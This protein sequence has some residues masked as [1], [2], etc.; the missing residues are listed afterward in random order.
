MSHAIKEKEQWKLLRATLNNEY[1]HND[2]WTKAF[3]LFK[4]R[5]ERKYF[6]P[7]Q[8]LIDNGTLEGEGFT[9]VTVQCAL[10]ESVASF[11]TGE[12]YKHGTK[13]FAFHY[14]E[15]KKMFVKFLTSEPVFSFYF[16]KDDN[17]PRKT[18]ERFDAGKF[19]NDVRCGLMHEAR[20]KEPWFINATQNH[21][22]AD[23][24]FLKRKGERI[25]IYRSILHVLI[26]ETYSKYYDDLR[27]ST[28]EGRTLRRFFAR[29]LDHLYDIGRNPAYEWWV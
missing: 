18:F 14:N 8:S 22:P 1:G 5:L 4:T 9:I 29:K 27:Q 25:Q 15:S 6:N 28:A 20:T 10:I 21:D 2:V 23:K 26:K 16:Y 17:D 3:N 24:V 13:E 19:Y 11:R 12:I 7:I